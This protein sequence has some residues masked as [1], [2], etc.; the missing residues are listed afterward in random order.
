[1]RWEPGAPTPRGIFVTQQRAALLATDRVELELELVAQGRGAADYLL[2]NRRVRDRWDAGRFDLV[3]VHYGLTGLATL[4]LPA[5]APRVF[6]FYGSDVNDAVQ[7]TVAF[8]VARSAARRVFV[9]ARLAALWPSPRNVVLPNGVD[10]AAC[11]PRPREEACRE[12][13]LDPARKWVL[14]GARPGKGAKG[15]DVFR[16]VLDRVRARVP[17]AGELILSEPGQP[18]ERVVAKLN[19][20]DLLLFTS[21]RG[22]EGSP[23]VVKEAACVGLPVVSTDVGDAAETLEGIEPGAVVPWPAASGERGSWLDALASASAAVLESG[24]RA[25]G[26]TRRA[27][28]RLEA[29][30]ERLLALYAEVAGEVQ[31]S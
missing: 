7:R 29:V 21:A 4:A 15:Y 13:G 31:R 5:G 1:M 27:N 12:L 10:F 24:R 18:Y 11:A 30:T 17:G 8:V 14:F 2:A 16:E 25:D 20:A 3:H 28:L 9:S 19:A 22:T 26:R 6:T 23:T